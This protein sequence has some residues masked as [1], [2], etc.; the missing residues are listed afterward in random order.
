MGLAISRSIVQSHGGGLWAVS[1]KDRGATF[2]FTIPIPTAARQTTV[3]T[4][5]RRVPRR[6]SWR[7]QKA[8][9]SAA[10]HLGPPR[11]SGVQRRAGRG[12]RADLPSRRGRHRRVTWRHDG[13]RARTP[14][15]RRHRPA[16]ALDRAHRSWKR[17]AAT[18]IRRSGIR[19]VSSQPTAHSATRNVAGAVA[20]PLTAT[21]PCRPSL[22]GSNRDAGDHNLADVN[23]SSLVFPC[24][25]ATI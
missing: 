13:H 18:R 24:A 5:A 12:G 16:P 19:G 15:A 8:A 4:R 23:A 11:G 7:V 25:R 9:D 6:W 14:T 17:A 3:A 20:T 10:E 21:P 22:A 2:R 1:N